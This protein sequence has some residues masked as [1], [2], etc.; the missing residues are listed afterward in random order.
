MSEQ[1]L[2]PAQAAV[3]QW[4]QRPQW[5]Q[6]VGYFRLCNLLYINR[7]TI[8]ALVRKGVIEVDQTGFR[9]RLILEGE[10]VSVPDDE[11]IP[12]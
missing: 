7:G 1:K 5:R 11:S 3:V 6:E 12:F 9:G 8:K 2:S 4:M 10:R